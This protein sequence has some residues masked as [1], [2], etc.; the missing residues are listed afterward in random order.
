MKPAHYPDAREF[1]AAVAACGLEERVH[2][3]DTLSGFL[4]AVVSAPELIHLS[5]WLPLIYIE[6]QDELE[7]GG[8]IDDFNL[9][10]KELMGLWN[11]WAVALGDDNDSGLVA[12]PPGYD[13]VNGEPA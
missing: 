9:L 2:D 12:L 4:L 1:A 7:I 6:E 11:Y 13:L 8:D 5:E 3:F 10:M